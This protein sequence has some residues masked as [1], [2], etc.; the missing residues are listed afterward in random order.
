MEKQNKV[1]IWIGRFNDRASLENYVRETYDDNGE[2]ISDFMKDFDID[3]YDED[4]SEYDFI[5][6][7][8]LLQIKNFSYS[9]SFLHNVLEKASNENGFKLLYDFEYSGKNTDSGK[10]KFIGSFDYSKV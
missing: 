2:M 4:L 8:N 7:D 10:L 5:E 6:N 3:F 9:N 1:S